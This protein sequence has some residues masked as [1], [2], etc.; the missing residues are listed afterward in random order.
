VVDTELATTPPDAAAAALAL[1]VPRVDPADPNAGFLATLVAGSPTEALAALATAPTPSVELRLR[2]LRARLELR[3]GEA[4]DTA[5]RA[6]EDEHPDDWRVVWYR[7]L[8]ALAIRSTESAG[9]REAAEAFDAVYDAFPGEAAPKLGL[10]VCAE[11]LGSGEDAAE[12]YRLV[13][14]TD[15]AYVSAAF[16]L[17][18]VLL[19]AGDRP[20]A[21]R[22]LEAVPEVSTHFTAARIGAVR[23]RLRGRTAQE[24][25]GPDLVECSEQLAALTLDARRREEL[26]VEVLDSA[27]AWV[28]AGL[29]GTGRDTTMRVLGHP[30][31][32]RELRFALEHSYRVL[33]RLSDRTETRIEM[34]ERA[35]RARPRTWV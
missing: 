20:G 21:V 31:G 10:A 28:L 14:S 33:A 26:A 29:P 4:V 1:P 17:A 23:A 18:R 12:F 27:L 16:G 22:A 34:V 24:P 25:L 3:D 11:L 7:G 35:N 2:E 13:G 9:V 15:R 32:E 30:A 6:L 5:L 19:A 8:A